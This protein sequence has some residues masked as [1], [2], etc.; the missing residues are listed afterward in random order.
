MVRRGAMG[1]ELV[2]GGRGCRRLLVVVFGIWGICGI[3]GLPG[4]QD[5]QEE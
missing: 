5:G 1:I 2:F 4:M 3:C